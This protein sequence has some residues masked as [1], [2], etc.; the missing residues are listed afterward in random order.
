MTVMMYP[1]NTRHSVDVR[2]DFPSI[3]KVVVG[4]LWCWKLSSAKNN[5]SSVFMPSTPNPFDSGVPIR[6]QELHVDVDVLKA[7]Q[8]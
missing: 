6:R 2:E 4:S 8:R 1:L 3:L 7:T 5:V